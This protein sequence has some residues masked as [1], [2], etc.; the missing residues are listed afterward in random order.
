MLVK[1]GSSYCGEH[2]I[3]EPSNHVTLK[4]NR[5]F[6]YFMILSLKTVTVVVRL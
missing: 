4:S 5:F 1:K 2:A 6:R 3:Y